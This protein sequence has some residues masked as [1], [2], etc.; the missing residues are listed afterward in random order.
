MADQSEALAQLAAGNQQQLTM[1]SDGPRVRNQD[2]RTS[3][4]EN[5]DSFQR[6]ILDERARRPTGIGIAEDTEE[7]I[8]DGISVVL[9]KRPMFP[10]EVHSGDYDAT[11]V[12]GR[13]IIVHD[14]RMKPDMVHMEM[15]H[16][17]YSFP[18]VFDEHTSNDAVYQATASPLV[19]HAAQ[20][21]TA[22][23]FMF[24]QTG[25]GKTYTM[26][27]IHERAVA[28][29]FAQLGESEQVVVSYV[30]LAGSSC[31]DML[32]G[33]STVDLMSDRRGEVQLCGMTELEAHD[34]DELL[35]VMTAANNARATCSTGVHDQSSRS[36]AVCRV[37]IRRPN[38]ADGMFTMVDLAGSERSKDSM[39]H[40]AQTQKET[41][42]INVSLMALKDCVR[43]ITKGSAHVNYR[44][45][46]LTQVLR[47]C[48]TD[49]SACTVVIATVSPS[50][51]DTDHTLGTLSHA[52][53]MDGQK[54]G[55]AGVNTV[56][57]ESAA[58]ILAKEVRQAAPKEPKKW[59]KEETEAWWRPAAA[60]ALK[61][62]KCP[63]PE[64][65]QAPFPRGD[66][67]GKTIL[68]WPQKRFEQE[69]G[70]KKAGELLHKALKKR[71]LD[72]ND[73]KKGVA[74][75]RRGDVSL[76][77]T[78]SSTSSARCSPQRGTPGSSAKKK[79]SVRKAGGSGPRPSA[80]PARTSKPRMSPRPT[81]PPSKLSIAKRSARGS[82]SNT[83]AAAAAAV[84][85]SPM[86][87]LT[88]PMS[89]RKATATPR[90][91]A[92]AAT[93]ATPSRA[94]PRRSG[95]G[96]GPAR[97][98]TRTPVGASQRG[99]GVDSSPSLESFLG[100]SAQ[101]SARK[102]ARAK[103]DAEKAMEYLAQLTANEEHEKQMALEAAGGG[104]GGGVDDL[105]TA[106]VGSTAVAP[107]GAI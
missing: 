18:R 52:I 105:L 46:S 66:T 47:S 17:T 85:R 104:G 82:T 22:T 99:G 10:K 73:L 3:R 32:N 80:S 54:E 102:N 88:A 4:I 77:S 35:Q 64:G 62:A 93:S 25:S 43:E 48:F 29:L 31:R 23:V 36:H 7:V 56:A 13:Q 75:V 65:E 101:S 89:N 59:T 57:V 106:S 76:Q 20:G 34:A 15:K 97:R 49:K 84:D 79:S 91:T 24:G 12:S 78:S 94:T 107:G 61:R 33:G 8:N 41:N 58:S 39:Y 50:S 44:A 45:S 96:L 87:P 70:N 103:R 83:A 63:V 53:L 95:S 21:G 19:R 67:S 16:H 11:T 69:L 86:S 38:Q 72:H 92:K 28:E 30:E 81:P 1:A 42:D 14:G 6:A 9:R 5:A 68:K 26:S 40:D 27:A 98:V 71:V 55:S 100:G 37:S 90:A 2:K 51:G 74:A 60:L